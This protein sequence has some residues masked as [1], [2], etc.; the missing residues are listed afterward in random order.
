MITRIL[1][2]AAISAI[3][4]YRI[5]ISPYYGPVCRYTPSCSHYAEEAL[6]KHGPFR[7][8]AMALQRLLRCH[9]FSAG[10][11]DPVR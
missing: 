1:K 10:G 5:A 7:G 6:K 4:I 11:H 2:S 8:S 9:P 3:R